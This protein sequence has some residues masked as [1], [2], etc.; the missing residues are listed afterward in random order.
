MG[1]LAFVSGI[2]VYLLTIMSWNTYSKNWICVPAS[3]QSVNLV[4]QD[5]SVCRI[6]CEYSYQFAD[7]IYQANRTDSSSHSK[8]VESQK[9][10]Y[11]ILKNHLD[12]SKS[13]FIYVNRM[14]PGETILF[15][16]PSFKMYWF[17]AVG[18]ACVVFGLV[19]CCNTLLKLRRIEPVIEE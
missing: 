16:E 15:R 11:D 8:D 5:G 14:N 1:V 18:L 4:K 19:M 13:F 2:S 17:L 3:I 10:R 6:E 7:S 12:S 9:A